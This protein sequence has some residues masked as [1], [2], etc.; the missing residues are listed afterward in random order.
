M[1]KP[2]FVLGVLLVLVVVP[3]SALNRGVSV[4]A[5]VHQT[6]PG[7]VV[8]VELMRLRNGGRM[9]AGVIQTLP[10]PNSTSLTRTVHFEN[11]EPGQYVVLANGAKPSQ[12]AGQRVDIEEWDVPPVS[13]QL[14][15][16]RLRLRTFRD[17]KTSDDTPP[18]RARVILR[19]QE[20]FWELPVETDGNGEATVDLWQ[21]GKWTATVESPGSVPFRSRR[22]IAEPVDT[23]WALEMPRLEVVGEVV[24]AE[25]GAPIANAGVALEMSSAEP[26]QHLTVSARAGRDGTFRFAPVFAGEHKIKAAAEGYP[27]NEVVYSFG[28]DEESHSLKIALQRTPM[29]RLS[30]ADA[31]GAPIAGA[32]VYVVRGE[33][34]VVAYG[35]TDA[36]GK[37]P[38]FIP[39]GE[40]RTVFVV[41]R[42]G[43]LGAMRIRS[44]TPEVAMTLVDGASRIVMHAESES[45]EPIPGISLDVRYNGFLLPVEVLE[46]LTA[47]GSRTSS[48]AEGQMVLT[49]MPAGVYELWPA[50]AGPN[51]APVRM[52]A[53][54]GDNVAVLTFV[55][56]N[57]R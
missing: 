44:G 3:I 25:S 57:G 9:P 30:V 41:P 29:T 50:P 39:D 54:A 20:A 23:D 15:P 13:V 5:A 35:R 53:K 4:D 27:A 48:D 16:F 32:S 47:R 51:Q 24:N 12:R 52:V 28:D 56:V 18:G 33:L 43:S 38:V 36:T 26:H 19:Q 40:E 45:H 31:H 10:L 6:E 17:P 1:S 22:T 46:A 21:G 34:A 14:M 37:T 8:S 42:D 2:L 55:R 49:H 11:V 7:Q